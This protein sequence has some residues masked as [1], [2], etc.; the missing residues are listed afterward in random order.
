MSN[1]SSNI[2]K[3]NTFDDLKNCVIN[4]HSKISNYF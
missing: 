1:N 4:Y 2:F 3:L